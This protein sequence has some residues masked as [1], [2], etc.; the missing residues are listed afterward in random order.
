MDSVPD[1]T[2]TVSDDSTSVCGSAMS[3]KRKPSDAAERRDV[4]D[5]PGDGTSVVVVQKKI[6]L[7]GHPSS[8]TGQV[9]V[10]T[11]LSACMI[12]RCSR[13]VML[14]IP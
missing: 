9:P 5:G 14:D 3:R 11:I 2:I 4:V 12:F 1:K 7:D 8:L 13:E 10:S 6:R